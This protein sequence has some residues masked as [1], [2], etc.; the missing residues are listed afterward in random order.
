VKKNWVLR[1][2]NCELRKD[3][4][5][6][7]KFLSANHANRKVEEPIIGCQKL[8]TNQLQHLP[9]RPATWV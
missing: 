7:I 9:E 3:F 6:K 5:V 4:L 1:D 8:I 2:R